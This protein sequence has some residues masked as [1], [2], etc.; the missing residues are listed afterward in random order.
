MEHQYE[1]SPLCTFRKS[2]KIH[3]G[4]LTSRAVNK[5]V[6]CQPHALWQYATGAVGTQQTSQLGFAQKS[7]L[8][9][10]QLALSW[11]D[12]HLCCVQKPYSLSEGL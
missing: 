9:V 10:V 8:T 6:V 5:A 7:F 12:V 11:T 4:F 3:L 2:W 1:S